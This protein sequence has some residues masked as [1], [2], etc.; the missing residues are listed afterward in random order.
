MRRRM[1][2]IGLDCAD[3]KLV[4]EEFWNDLPNIRKIAESG[5]YGSLE[6]T[7]PPITVPAWM[8]MV[9]GKDPGELGIYGFRNRK[10]FSYD[11]LF[12]A[13]SRLIK[14]ETVWETL[15]K[16][17]YKSIILGVPLT[18]PPKP[19]KGYLVS[20]FLAPSTESE[21]T[22]PKE[23]KKE[24]EKWVGNYMLDVENFRTNDKERLLRDIYRM[25]EQRFEVAKH[26]VTEKEWDFF[27]MVEMGPDRIHHGFWAY[28]DPEH[29]KH[30]PNSPY[31]NAIKDYYKFL[32]KK[33]GELIEVLPKDT[34]I[35]IVSDH[36]IQRMDGGIAVN[37]WLIEKG[38]LTLKEK[39]EKPA[40]ISDLI[41]NN[42]IDWKRTIAWGEGG[43]YGRIFLNVKGREPEG[44]VEDYEKTRDELIKEL[45][46]ITDEYGNNIGTRVFKPEEVYKKVENIPPDLIVYFGNLRWR[47]IGTVGN[48]T[49]WLHEN[50]TG[51][52]DANHAQYGIV[53]VSDGKVPE[54]IY[55][56]RDFILKSFGIA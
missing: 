38:Y 10:D 34:L 4:F 22:Y 11:S 20:G 43:Y 2:I 41:K 48:D 50:D 35:M 52:D 53:I 55:E 47:S 44:V 1:A 28:H 21:Y 36:G 51:P 16:H 26:L 14:Y 40:R 23:L 54:K 37:D 3:P 33:V 25:T 30:D 5:S 32:D 17:G 46:S 18:Y 49:I 29:F 45:E 13:N 27:M 31:R 24:I 39:L 19:L 12:F 8:C 42:M 7:I 15:G 6:S 9:T 56:V